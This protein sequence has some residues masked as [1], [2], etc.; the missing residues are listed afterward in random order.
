MVS[1]SPPH[2]PTAPCVWG[3]DGLFLLRRGG[4]GDLRGA[5]HLLTPDKAFLQLP[6]YRARFNPK[7]GSCITASW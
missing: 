2:T 6:H 7:A 5:D 1:D 4:D 3:A